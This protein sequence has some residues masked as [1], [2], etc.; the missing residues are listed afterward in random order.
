MNPFD[1]M[2]DVQGLKEKMKDARERLKG[3]TVT[4]SSGGDMVEVDM[5]GEFSVL[6]VRISAD[7]VNPDEREM[8]EDLVL[9]A[10][11]DATAK[12]RE[13]MK[14]EISEVTG[15]LP[16]NDLNNMMGLT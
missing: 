10:V 4:G 3:I 16:L 1:M 5:N 2:K 11:S 8:L 9:A 6:D 15:G 14:H 13:S 7:V 12:L